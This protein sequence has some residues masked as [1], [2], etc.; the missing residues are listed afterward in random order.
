LPVAATLSAS[1]DLPLDRLFVTARDFEAV[2]YLS[3][4]APVERREEIEA[5]GRTVVVLPADGGIRAMLGHMRHELGAQV[6]L[7]EGGPT[8]NAQLFALGC[9][10][11]YFLTLGPVIVAGRDTLTAVEGAR[12]FGREAVKRLELVAAAPNEETGEVYLRYRVRP[13]AS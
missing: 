4:A 12:A 11:E 8:V 2:V 7:A 5:T 3:G 13:R 9:V 10:D 6:L 1:G